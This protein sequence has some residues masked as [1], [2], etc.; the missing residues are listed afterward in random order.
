MEMNYD[1]AVGFRLIDI[2]KALQMLTAG[3]PF[4]SMCMY[5]SEYD[6]N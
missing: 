1:E 3:R 6:N 5:H 2:P 4:T